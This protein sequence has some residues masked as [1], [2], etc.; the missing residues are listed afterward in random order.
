MA[1]HKAASG[2]GTSAPRE[3]T[4]G[5]GTAA[6]RRGTKRNAAAPSDG[7]SPRRTPLGSVTNNVPV[8]PKPAVTKPAT[9]GKVELIAGYDAAIAGYEDCIAKCKTLSDE[10]TKAIAECK[11]LIERSMDF[12]KPVDDLVDDLPDCAPGTEIT[13]PNFK[14]KAGKW[15][16]ATK[17][18]V[19]PFLAKAFADNLNNKKTFIRVGTEHPNNTNEYV[20]TNYSTSFGGGGPLFKFVEYYLKKDF[21]RD[22]LAAFPGIVLEVK[23]SGMHVFLSNTAMFNMHQDEMENNKEEAM[24]FVHVGHSGTWVQETGVH[25]QKSRVERSHG[26]VVSMTK[27][28]RRLSHGFKLPK[29]LGATLLIRI[30]LKDG[31]DEE[32]IN[33]IRHRL[34]VAVNALMIAFDAMTAKPDHTKLA[35]DGGPRALPWKAFTPADTTDHNVIR[36]KAG[37]LAGWSTPEKRESHE[38][39]YVVGKSKNRE[40]QEAWAA[41][42]SDREEVAVMVGERKTAVAARRAAVLT[43]F[44]GREK[45]LRAALKK[46]NADVKAEDKELKETEVKRRTEVEAKFEKLLAAAEATRRGDETVD[47]T[48][49]KQRKTTKGAGANGGK[50]LRKGCPHGRESRRCKECGGASICEHGRER[51]KC[52]DCGGASICEHSRQRSHCKDCGG[53]SICEHSR[54]RS[55]CKECKK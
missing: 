14:G 28:A 7:P 45:E 26:C 13:L 1:P 20:S 16:K 15:L 39:F 27:H 35:E 25:G 37:G 22:L 36:G 21:I 32:I 6:P 10:N 3:V 24:F 47:G 29:D 17:K 41:E 42:K 53:A 18:A 46:F 9:G 4:G 44:K 8:V 34:A 54:Q 5:G 50:R 48:T 51:S 38:L 33:N 43:E 2:G 52:K 23:V 30:R 12:T 40:V 19:K 55:Q 11:K 31:A 49:L